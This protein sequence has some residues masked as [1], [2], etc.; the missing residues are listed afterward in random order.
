MQQFHCILLREGRVKIITRSA[1]GVS[2]R[3]RGVLWVFKLLKLRVCDIP[4][5]SYVKAPRR[6]PLFCLDKPSCRNRVQVVLIPMP[7]ELDVRLKRVR[8]ECL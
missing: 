8:L 2:E 5:Y 1:F 6:F 3:I 4:Y 7:L